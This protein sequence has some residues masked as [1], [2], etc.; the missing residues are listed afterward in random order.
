MFSEDLT[1]FINPGTPGYVLANYNGADINALFDAPSADDFNISGQSMT[2]H[3]L[4]EDVDAT[5]V[6]GV[7]VTVNGVS[8]TVK[9]ADADG[10][11]ITKLYLAKT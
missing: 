8:Y 5:A 3:C 9:S 2:L 10:T 1:A 6:R 7:P 11:G 4:G